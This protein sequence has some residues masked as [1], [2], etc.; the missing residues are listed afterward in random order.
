MLRVDSRIYHETK[1][2]NDSTLDIW[3]SKIVVEEFLNSQV[4]SSKSAFC[5]ESRADPV[6]DDSFIKMFLELPISLF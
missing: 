3:P 1:I 2:K 5:P 4:P 6:S